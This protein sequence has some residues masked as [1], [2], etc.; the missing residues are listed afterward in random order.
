MSSIVLQQPVAI[1]AAATA[2]AMR[3]ISGEFPQTQLPG[4]CR[5]PWKPVARRRFVPRSTFRG[6]EIRYDSRR[7]QVILLRNTALSANPEDMKFLGERGTLAQDL[8]AS[9]VVCLVALPLCMGIAIASG[10]PPATGLITGVIGGIVAGAL[11]GCPLQVSGPAAGLAVIV[12]ELVQKF[13]LAGLGPIIVLAGI[14]QFSAGLLKAGQLFRAMAPA[15]IYGML[16]GI[17]VLIFG[18][19]FHVMVDDKPHANGIE[20]LLS[21]PTAIQKG[22]FPVDGS[23][24]HIAAVLGVATIVV[25]LGW[26][27]FAP[28]K[29][30][31]IPGALVAVAVSTAVAQVLALPVRRV[32]LP[33]GFLAS[34][35]LPPFNSFQ[36]VL[37]LDA[38]IAALTIAFVASAETLLS[39]TAVDQMHDGPRTNYD[40][41]LRSQGVGNVISGLLGGIPMTGVI[42]R[43]A[44]NVAAGARTRRS[45][46]LHGVWL[47]LLVAA[48]P[49][50]LRM[51]PTASLAAV[52]VYTGYKLVNPQNVK[53]LLHYGGVPVFI[54]AATL[55][56]IVLTDL[57]TGILTGLALS[58]VKV[59][60]GLT[61]MQVRITSRSHGR[62]DLH[63]IGAATFI[64]MP[65]LV[66]ALNALPQNEAVHIHFDRLVYIDHA[67]MDALY[68][69]KRQRSEKGAPVVMEWSDLMAHYRERN[70]LR[71]TAELAEVVSR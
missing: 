13:G 9:V 52:L 29:L 49:F 6:T 26:T 61:H 15:V 23:S 4:V 18:A 33:D 53:K 39:A 30:K 70:S 36:S 66:D 45:T 48:F 10:V 51:V 31:W 12:Y 38:F 46:M 64:R 40:K 50:V 20:N 68:A 5:Q 21:I 67:C 58:V 25:L 8:M 22:I 1:A 44:T 11:S 19:Q 28:R 2:S 41:E 37:Q 63:I 16:A 65:S 27:K 69:W 32:D 14:I 34:L 60:Y 35:H 56:T 24:H 43:S 54:Y 57:L 55:I 7:I 47:L 71:P 62:I 59:L 17:G 42:V 3:D